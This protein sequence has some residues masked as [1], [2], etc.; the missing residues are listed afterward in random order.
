MKRLC[1]SPVV[2]DPVNL[3]FEGRAKIPS[4]AARLRLVA[5]PLFEAIYGD[6]LLAYGPSRAPEGFA[7]ESFVLILP[8]MWGGEIAVRVL[9]YGFPA[10]EVD[11]F[12]PYFEAEFL[13]EE[14]ATLA[15]ASSFAFA[16]VP[17]YLRR[18]CRYSYRRGFV[19]RYDEGRRE[20]V[21]LPMKEVEP[22]AVLGSFDAERITE[23]FPVSASPIAPFHGFEEDAGPG[24]CGD[25]LFRGVNRFDV[26]KEFLDVTREGHS[27]IE[28]DFGV[29]EAAIFHL[30]VESPAE[31]DAFLVFD[32]AKTKRGWRFR[33]SGAQDLLTIRLKKGRNVLLSAAP[34]CLRFARLIFAY[35]LKAEISLFLL[36]NQDLLPYQEDEDEDIALIQKAARKSFAENAYDILTDCPGRERTGWL[37]DSFFTGRAESHFTGK[38]DRERNFLEN[39]LV[40]EAKEI[41]K[42]MIPMCFPSE[43]ITHMFLPNW[44]MWFVLEMEDYASR[45]GDRSLLEKGRGKIEGLFSFLAAYENEQGLLENLGSSIGD[46]FAH[47]AKDP[48]SWLF[49]EWS[50][51]ANYVDGVHFP[52]NMLYAASL[53]AYGRMYRESGALQ[54]AG[55]IRERVQSLS[56]FNHFYHDHAKRDADGALSPVKEH[57]SEACQYYALF[58]GFE[59]EEGFFEKMARDF[60]PLGAKR[61]QIDPCAPFIGFLLRLDVLRSHGKEE[62]LRNEA[63]AFYA[64]MAKRTGTLWETFE[65]SSSLNHAVSSYVG[66]LLEEKGEGKRENHD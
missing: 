2:D 44:A 13:N 9:S 48:Q 30:E 26:Q 17:S 66:V 58:F 28:W 40:G 47:K 35:P 36:E 42:G 65:D 56:F 12:E 32:E 46:L 53:E 7:R 31:Q 24:L 59:G 10:G 19:E 5:G 3:F 6:R 45:S 8:K 54:K 64:P 61:G 16:L 23:A 39:F 62:K 50:N 34:Y 29:N 18:S 37:C 14:G 11:L 49:I 63:K 55:K 21:P 4:G 27:Y 60:G 38:A 33:R 25:P 57:V 51:A 15:D 41:R 20:G 1:L 52:T 43:E 22:P